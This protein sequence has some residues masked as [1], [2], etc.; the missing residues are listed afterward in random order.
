M[1]NFKDRLNL[2]KNRKGIKASSVAMKMDEALRS[3]GQEN[4]AIRYPNK[5]TSP[6]QANKP[7]IHRVYEPPTSLH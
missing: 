5:P 1:I 3:A 4:S 7:E 2:N 6:K